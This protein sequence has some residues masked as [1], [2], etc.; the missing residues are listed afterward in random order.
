[1]K[2]SDFL[3]LC[4][5]ML[6]AT[7]LPKAVWAQ[8]NKPADGPQSLKNIRRITINAGATKPFGALHISD[9]HLTRVDERDNERKKSLSAA[10]QRAFKW[11]E[12]YFDAA[13]RYARERDLMLLH[14]GDLKEEDGIVF[15]PLYMMML[16]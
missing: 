4:G 6:L 1:M 7:Q 9:T 2:R 11:A 13:I 16:L 5:G 8:A 3:R 12:H 15:L 10:R 14:T